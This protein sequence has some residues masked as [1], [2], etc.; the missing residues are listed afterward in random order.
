MTHFTIFPAIDLRNGAVV[1]LQQGDPERQTTYSHDPLAFA[2][3]WADEGAAWLHVVNLD[4]A[5]GAADASAANRAVLAK[6]AGAVGLK[7]QFGG[8]V[9]SLADAQA[10][11]DAGV[12]RVV[13]GTAAVEQ[14]ELV[15][16]ILRR[17]GPESLIVGLDSKDGM[18]VTRGWRQPMPISAIDYGL[19]MRARGVRHALY[20]EVGRDGMLQ[21][22]AA[23]LTAA[24]AQ[25]TGLSV[26][27]SGGVRHVD[28]VRELCLY[29]PR[30]VSGVVIGRALYDGTLTLADAL[31]AA[32]DAAAA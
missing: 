7:I 5:F 14:P 32:R 12:T 10:A 2:R 11:F 28:D 24:L 15:D 6:I 21:G 8:G 23:E 3:R 17:F 18:L 19:D 20:T 26:L 4:G 1:R 29:A 9:R 13:I 27:A 31:A 25:L 16:A 22:V 30:G